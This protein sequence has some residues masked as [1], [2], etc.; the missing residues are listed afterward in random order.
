MKDHLKEKELLLIIDNCEHLIKEC[1]ITVEMLLS[2]STNLKIITTSRESLNCSGE[3]IYR[4]PSLSLPDVSVNNTPL[5]LSKYES[6]RLFI[7]RAIAVNREFRVNNENAPA[8]AEICFR[9]DGI[10]LAKINVMEILDLLNALT[11]KSIIIYDIEMERYRILE[12][13]KQYGEDKLR[14]SG[15]KEVILFNHLKH[16]MEFAEKAGPKL[17]SNEI[18]HW[19][20]KLEQDHGNFQSAIKWS[21]SADE[22]D[23]GTGLQLHWEIS[24]IVAGI[25]HWEDR[26]WKILL[27]YTRGLNKSLSVNLIRFAGILSAGQ[28]DYEQARKYFEE[29]LFLTRELGEKKVIAMSLNQ[30]GG[31]ELFSRR[32][33]QA[34]KYYEESLLLYRELGEKGF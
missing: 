23:K 33:E 16:F 29:C 9:L 6:V 3:K 7:E 5:Q 22:T 34:Q 24:G 31:T 20:K 13:L 21:L 18:H 26:S 8:L 11:E 32:I 17:H 19:L 4:V 25:I 10:P 2:N 1:A 28:S 12:T 30:L 14:D 27:L 15:R